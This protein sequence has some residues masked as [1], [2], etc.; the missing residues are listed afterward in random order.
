MFLLKTKAVNSKLAGWRKLGTVVAKL[1][2]RGF[3][4]IA[5]ILAVMGIVALI[6]KYLPALL[7]VIV[8]LVV[9]VAVGGITS[10]PDDSY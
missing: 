8:F 7:I 2:M 3:F 10:Y 5:S 4:I 9:C 1:A 6:I